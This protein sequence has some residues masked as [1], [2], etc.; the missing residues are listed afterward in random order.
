[1]LRPGLIIVIVAAL[2]VATGAQGL[3]GWQVRVDQSRNAQDPDSVPD[4]KT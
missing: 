2:T 4:I 1:M 3:N